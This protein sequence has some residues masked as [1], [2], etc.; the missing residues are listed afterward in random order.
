MA[1][2]RTIL[3]RTR[4]PPHHIPKFSKKSTRNIRTKDRNITLIPNKS[5]TGIWKFSPA[6]YIDI[7]DFFPAPAPWLP[8]PYFETYDFCP[9][10]APDIPAPYFKILEK[11]PAP[12]A[13]CG[14]EIPG[15][16][17]DHMSALQSY[18]RIVV[19]VPYSN[20]HIKILT[21]LGD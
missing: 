1:R 5:T 21:T 20:D 9:A 15:P 12:G 13:G 19:M 3:T 4:V 10:P 2:T 17:F 7:F 16:V 8:A 14:T 11:V 6:P 18:H